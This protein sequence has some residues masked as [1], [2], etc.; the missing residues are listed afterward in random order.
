MTAG[1]HLGNGLVSY[2]TLASVDTKIE[3]FFRSCFEEF[4]K[5]GVSAVAIAA[6][7]NGTQTS[8]TSDFLMLVETLWRRSE[9]SSSKTK[10]ED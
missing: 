7:N 4:S 5:E 1:L 2:Q 3:I 8:R 10:L 6:N 9:Y